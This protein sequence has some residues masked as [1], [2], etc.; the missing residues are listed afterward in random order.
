MQ[1]RDRLQRKEI[2]LMLVRRIEELPRRQRKVLAMYYFE[3]VSLAQIGACFGPTKCDI[4][5]LHAEAVGLLKTML[6][7][8]LG[9]Q[10]LAASTIDV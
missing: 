3:D 2:I 10:Q 7:A 9:H 5:Q 1:E 4:D 8:Q 6:A